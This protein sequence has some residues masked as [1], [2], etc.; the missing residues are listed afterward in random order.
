MAEINK[1]WV[2]KRNSFLLQDKDEAC[3]LCKENLKLIEEEAGVLK[4]LALVYAPILDHALN[5]PKC[6]HLVLQSG[7]KA[8]NAMIY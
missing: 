7:E 5:C 6:A 4:D 1:E 3:D 2:K 8:R